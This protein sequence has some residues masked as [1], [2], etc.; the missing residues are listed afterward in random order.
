MDGLEEAYVT[1]GR[2]GELTGEGYIVGADATGIMTETTLRVEDQYMN[3]AKYFNNAIQSQIAHKQTFLSVAPNWKEQH[4]RNLRMSNPGYFGNAPINEGIG[5]GLMAAGPHYISGAAEAALAMDI[6]AN[7]LVNNGNLYK[8]IANADL[9]DYGLQKLGIALTKNPINEGLLNAAG[10]AMFDVSVSGGFSAWGYGKSTNHVLIDAS[11]SLVLL[12]AQMFSINLSKKIDDIGVEVKGLRSDLN[13]AYK[14][15]DI[16]HGKQIQQRLNTLQN[17]LNGYKRVFE[18][19]Q[20]TIHFLENNTA[21]PAVEK[22]AQLHL[23]Q[24][25]Q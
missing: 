15:F 5:Y 17:Q 13:T 24:Q 4:K 11:V 20:K 18:E 3:G 7:T 9:F 22:N 2:A 6:L 1:M 8:G 23:K 25:I 21:M 14:N 16:D 19:N 10:G 12:R